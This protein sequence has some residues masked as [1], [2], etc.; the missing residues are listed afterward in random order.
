MSFPVNA[1]PIPTALLKCIFLSAL[2]LD[3]QLAAFQSDDVRAN[4]S[5]IYNSL[6]PTPT[7]TSA[8]I[9]A[10]STS[11]SVAALPEMPAAES[12]LI[13]VG[14]I[15]SVATFPT[16]NHR[17]AYTEFTIRLV[18]V[19][20][21]NTD[22]KLEPTSSNTDA[23]LGRLAVLAPGGQYKGPDGVVINHEVQG[24]GH[25]LAKSRKYL[26]FLRTRRAAQCSL[27]LKA[28]DLTDG[29]AKPLATDDLNRAN[30]GLSLYTGLPEAQI[31]A[32]ARQQKAGRKPLD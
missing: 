29:R 3:A 22:M 27:I 32:T 23:P 7:A 14:S 5:R 30:N 28:W 9:V 24:T 10:V 26:L 18:E 25:A 1:F 13:V 2:L 21:N 19:I 4:R 11:A 8:P 20:S 17:A 6:A 15:E 12:D 31:L 16:E